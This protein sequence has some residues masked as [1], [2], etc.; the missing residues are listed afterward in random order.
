MHHGLFSPVVLLIYFLFIA[1][2]KLCLAQVVVSVTNSVE[3][4]K[5]ELTPTQSAHE[6]TQAARQRARFNSL[7]LGSALGSL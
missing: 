2:K 4:K 3:S 6:P 7:I 5:R 1:A